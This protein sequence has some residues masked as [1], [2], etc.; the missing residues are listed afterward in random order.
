MA[1]TVSLEQE[2][3]VNVE[4]GST[5]KFQCSAQGF[6]SP[7]VKWQ[8][9]SSPGH[10]VSSGPELT[11]TSVT[12]DMSASYRC[13]A[14][15]SEGSSHQTLTINVLCEYLVSNRQQQKF[16]EENRL[17]SAPFD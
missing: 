3:L 15:N 5:A 16:L 1:P 14:T 9:E 2:E 8:L 4:E 7:S 12:P 17:P 10:T 6:P 11:L 13:V